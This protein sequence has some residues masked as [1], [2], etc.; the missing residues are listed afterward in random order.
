MTLSLAIAINAVAMFT[1]VGLLTFA[2]SR[3]ARLRPH[4]G[5]AATPATPA[6]EQIQHRRSAPAPRARRA[7]R[8][9]TV[10]S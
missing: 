7:A 9:A 6:V 8:L 5:S 10:R 2:M 3:A 1:L 4:V